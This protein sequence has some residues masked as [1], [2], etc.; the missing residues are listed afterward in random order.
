MITFTFEGDESDGVPPISV[1]I[2]EALLKSKGETFLSQLASPAWNSGGSRQ[3][4]FSLEPLVSIGETWH[5]S[6]AG[7][8]LK[9]YKSESITLPRDVEL[10]ELITTLDFF[11][12][13]P[14]GGVAGIDLSECSIGQRMRANAHIK[15]NEM[16]RIAF[17]SIKQIL[18]S[19]RAL[20]VH[21]I[22]RHSQNCLSTINEFSSVVYQDVVPRGLGV[23]ISDH[24]GWSSEESFREKLR[25]MLDE[26]DLDVEWKKLLLTFKEGMHYEDA[27]ETGFFWTLKVTPKS[28]EPIKKRRRIA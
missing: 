23:N 16:F 3:N 13:K 8:I 27:N 1:E 7:L 28:P 20:S 4:T 21:F 9:C 26:H 14:Q 24:M 18:K 5:P 15:N 6:M 2:S 25:G 22:L 12:V 10:S 17:Q 11:G 19:S